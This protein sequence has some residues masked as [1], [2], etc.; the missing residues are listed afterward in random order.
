MSRMIKAPG[1]IKDKY[2]DIKTKFT[3]VKDENQETI[4]RCRHLEGLVEED[5]KKDGSHSRLL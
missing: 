3:T 1:G 5:M 4:N 2:K